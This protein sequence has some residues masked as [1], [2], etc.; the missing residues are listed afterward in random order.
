MDYSKLNP[1]E[2]TRL[3]WEDAAVTVIATFEDKP[4]IIILISDIIIM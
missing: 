1:A 3:R 4:M 2:V